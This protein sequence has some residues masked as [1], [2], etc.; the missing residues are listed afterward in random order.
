MMS[1]TYLFWAPSLFLDRHLETESELQSKKPRD[2]KQRIVSN[3]TKRIEAIIEKQQPYIGTRLISQTCRLVVV[4]D[5]FLADLS[6]FDRRFRNVNSVN[7]VTF[8]SLLI[9]LKHFFGSFN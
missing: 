6:F 9:Q 8:L 3:T 2:C 7:I 4:E 1:S 5:K